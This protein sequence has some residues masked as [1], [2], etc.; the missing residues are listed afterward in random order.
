MTSRQKKILQRKLES[1]TPEDMA[2]IWKRNFNKKL[3]KEEKEQ[4][5]SVR[6]HYKKITGK[7][8]PAHTSDRK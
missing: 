6:K 7:M 8:L 4:F 5:E 1:L 3:D 2:E